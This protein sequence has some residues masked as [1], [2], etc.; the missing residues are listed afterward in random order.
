M[1]TNMYECLLKLFWMQDRERDTN[2]FHRKIWKFAF[3]LY[4]LDYDSVVNR[5][6][7]HIE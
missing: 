7:S 5:K 4:T 6:V 2:V 1:Y 3:W